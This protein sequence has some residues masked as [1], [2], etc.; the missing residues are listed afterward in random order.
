MLLMK[1]LHIGPLNSVTIGEDQI[2]WVKHNRLLYIIIDDRF[3]WSHHLTDV[4]KTFVNKHSLLMRSSFLSRD[5]FLDLS[6]G[7]I[8]LMWNC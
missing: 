2:E 6:F 8:A 4:K 1:K 3:F 7:S 5:A